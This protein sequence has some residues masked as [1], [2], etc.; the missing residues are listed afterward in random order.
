MMLVPTIISGGSGARLWPVSRK[1]RPKPFLQLADGRSL[2]QHAFLRATCLPDVAD[3]L[4]ITNRDLLFDT[5]REYDGVNPGKIGTPMLLEPVARDTAPAIAAATLYVRKAYGD[6]A[7][8]FLLPA[9]HIVHDLPAFRRAVERA[10]QLAHEDRIVTLGIRPTYP[11]TGYGYIEANGED[12]VRFVEKPDLERARDY[13]LSGTCY[14]NAGMLCFKASE[15]LRQLEA[16]CPD[17]LAACTQSLATSEAIGQPSYDGITLDAASFSE[18]PAVS[19]DYA[20]LEKA[21]NIAMVAC[22]IGWSDVGSWDAIAKLSDADSAGNTVQGDA[23]LI[24]CENVYVQGQNRLVGAVGLSDMVIV[25]TPDALLVAARDRLQ[26]VK[27]LFAQLKTAGHPA[28]DVHSTVIRPWGS[29]TVLEEGERFKIKRIVVT[30]GASLSLQKHHHRSE[31]WVVVSG[32][33]KVVNGSQEFMLETNQSTYIEKEQ[34]HRLENPTNAP[35]VIIEVQSGDYLG[36]DDI[37]RFDDIY[38]RSGT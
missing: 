12:V 38:G 5:K 24:G 11:E 25:D 28:Y 2:L 32:R 17:I 4:T 13:V 35:L 6:D 30:P 9:D 8:M 18:A 1:A 19:L 3:V 15:M 14:W 29:Y 7:L 21:S 31:H 10:M 22:D 37:V 16:H 34:K 33:A 23:V 20:L 27:G 36:E 26:D